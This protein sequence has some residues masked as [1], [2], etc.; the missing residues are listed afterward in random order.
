MS[1]AERADG[2]FGITAR[3]S[4]PVREVRA[5]IV[6][7][8]A[9]SYI[10]VVNPTMLGD[11]GM[12]VSHVFTATVLSAAVATLVMALYARYPI[13]QGPGMGINAFFTYTIVLAMGYTWEQALAATFVAGVLFFILSVGKI[14]RAM[15][16]AIPSDLRLSIAAG[17]GCFLLIVGLNGSHIIVASSSTL[18]TLGNLT[19]PAVALAIFGI[20]LTVV[21]YLKKITG[22]I[23]IGMIVTAAFGMIIGVIDVP[24]KLFA[25]PEMPDVGA[26]LTGLETVPWDLSF[27]V[28]IFSMLLVDFFDST[29]TIMSVGQKAGLLEPD[30]DLKEGNKPFVSDAVGTICG[31]VLGVS[32]VTSYAESTTGIA[33]GGRT[34]LM[35]LTVAGLF[36]VSLFLWPVLSVV[37]Y[38]CTVAALVIVAVIMMTTLKDLHWQ[39]PVAALTAV[40]TIAFMMLTYS[41]TD[42]MGFGLLFY[43]VGMLATGRRR[44]VSPV[45]YALTAV[46]IIYFAVTAASF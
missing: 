33:A 12:N 29:G 34:G 41:I 13:A 2:F 15:I 24:S 17:I 6:T 4:T 11:A 42:G 14:R 18:V 26:F 37:S 36:L 45:I 8:L 27:I 38:P 44:K 16:M 23:F 30:G 1:L 25:V 46:F 32:S 21:L 20:F 5:G 31:A 22:S 19:D 35:A 7:F 28:I 9:M 3:G 40:G 43:T 39:D 10:M